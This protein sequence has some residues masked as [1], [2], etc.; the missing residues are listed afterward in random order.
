MATDTFP[1][2]NMKISR[3]EKL[4]KEINFDEIED[5]FVEDEEDKKVRFGDLY[6]DQKTIIIFARVRCGCPSREQ[7]NDPLSDR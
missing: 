5:I 6:K 7:V 4:E 3:G 2:E 1:V